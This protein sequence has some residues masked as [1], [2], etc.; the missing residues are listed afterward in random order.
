MFVA[1]YLKFDKPFKRQDIPSKS[2]DLE[3]GPKFP[4]LLK[5][6][7]PLNNVADPNYFFHLRGGFIFY[8]GV[9]LRSDN[10]KLSAVIIRT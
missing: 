9:L 7:C 3:V 8:I 4:P 1:V 5:I 10:H 2:R 6:S